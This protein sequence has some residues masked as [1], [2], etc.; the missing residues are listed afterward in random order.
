MS[1]LKT[2]NIE[3]LDAST[4]A[5]QV[6]VGGGVNITGVTTVGDNLTIDGVNRNITTGVGQTVGFGT[7]ISIGGNLKSNGNSFVFPSSGGT[8]DRLERAGNILQVVSTNW[9]DQKIYANGD[10][11]GQT[12]TAGFT[13]IPS[14][15]YVNITATASNSKYYVIWDTNSSASGT[16]QSDWIGGA[17]LVVDPAG[18]TSW[19]RIG[20]GQNA[21]QGANVKYFLS[22]AWPASSMF[23][24]DSFWLMQFHGTY[25]YTSSVSA[26]N[27]LRFAV[28]YFHYDSA[29]HPEL[30]INRNPNN[31][32]GSNVYQGSFA[33]T[34]TVMEVAS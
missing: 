8:L 22:R 17:G 9:N 2:N 1:T 7:D 28:E 27:T 3:H 11:S 18:G 10:G 23:D 30:L 26:G 29:G 32:T 20:S 24:N 19:A 12:L 21:G 4:P 31:T 33:S 14:E 34:I 25:L 15:G 16:Q 13:V 5:I 6:A